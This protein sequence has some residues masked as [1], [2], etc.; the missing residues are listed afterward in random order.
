MKLIF[1][2]EKQLNFIQRQNMQFG[3]AADVSME[4]NKM[5]FL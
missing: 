3:A 4:K 2:V 1:Q 5:P